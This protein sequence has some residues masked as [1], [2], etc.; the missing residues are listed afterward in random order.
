MPSSIEVSLAVV[1]DAPIA[2][3]AIAASA[4]LSIPIGERCCC[5][6]PSSFRMAAFCGGR[7]GTGLL[8]CSDLLPPRAG[9]RT[10]AKPLW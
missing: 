7:R 4:G 1:A 9:L 6:I 3:I 5:P 10:Y 2:S 8:R